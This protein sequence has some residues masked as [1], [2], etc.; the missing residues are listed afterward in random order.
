MTRETNNSAHETKTVQPVCDHC[1]LATSRKDAV[2]DTVAGEEKVFCCGGCKGVY[3]LIIESGLGDF[4]KRR[5][6]SV[7]GVP[8]GVF[9]E[10]AS[11]PRC[12]EYATDAEGMAEETFCIEGIRCASCVWL[13]EKVLGRTPGIVSARVNYGTHR[14]KVIWDPKVLD[15]SGIVRKVR[16]IGYIARPYKPGEADDED[17]R[18]SR[19]L[20]VRFGTAAFFSMNLMV[21]SVALY[22]GYFQGMDERF[23][24]LLQVMAGIAATPV[25]FYCGWPFI[26]GAVRGLVNLAPGMDLLVA[27]GAG[28]AYFYSVAAMFLGGEVY[29]DTSSMIVTLILLGRYFELRARAKASEAV[30]RL[31]ALGVRDARVLRD[32][33]RVMVPVADLKLDELVEVRPGEKVP[34]DGVIVEGGGAVDESVITGES[35]PAGKSAGDR[36]V[37]ATMNIDGALVVKVSAV[38][39][40]SVLAKIIRLV[41]EAQA[42]R[43]PIQ[44]LADRVSEVFVPAVILLAVATAGYWYFMAGMRGATPALVNAVTVLVIACPCALGLATPIAVMVGTGLAAGR[45]VLFRGG[46]VL[47]RMSR[48]DT[49]VFDKT[50]TLTKGEMAVVDVIPVDGVTEE[51][52]LSVAASAEELSEHPVGRAVHAAAER[53]GVPLVGRRGFKALPGL[54]VQAELDGGL[55]LAGKASL[56]ESSSCAIRIDLKTEADRLSS[57]GKTP[58]YVSQ[59]GYVLGVLGVADELRGS[60]PD[61]VRTLKDAG[62]RVAMMTGDNHATAAAV[63]GSCGIDEVHSGLTPADKADRIKELKNTGRVVCMVGDGINDAPALAASDVGVA[64][65]RG[66]EIAIESAGVVLMKDDMHDAAYAI[67]LSRRSMSVIR[68][69]LFWAFFYNMLGLPVAASGLLSPVIAAGAMALSSVSVVGNSLRIKR[70][71]R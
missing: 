41:E 5:E 10:D 50:G 54:G 44:R 60:T 21:Y 6:W 53:R 68:Q 56:I 42:N 25:Y 14:A 55:A 36:V 18:Q 71:W 31:T 28:A 23:R 35:R 8:K 57:E 3:R 51:R 27:M 64:V 39:G 13:N 43:A 29:F 46:D 7:P 19:D 9:D 17:A 26:K 32:G 16:S 38:G 12:I 2:Y 22:A 37:G 33:R 20:L 11:E 24:T 47:E 66:T 69:N 49:V 62:I 34:A 65:G 30:S 45:G 52:L 67:L 63:A 61:A 4:Y 58:V 1:G 48:V 40:D 59:S 15:A 70:G